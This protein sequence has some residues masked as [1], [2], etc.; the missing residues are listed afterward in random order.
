MI[1]LIMISRL[2]A[3][4]E[5][6]IHVC[7]T[8]TRLLA[9][10]GTAHKHTRLESDRRP[11]IRDHGG[12]CKI[13]CNSW[14]QR[15]VNSIARAHE[16]SGFAAACVTLLTGLTWAQASQN[17]MQSDHQNSHNVLTDHAM[18]GICP[19]T[20]MQRV[21]RTGL[22]VVSACHIRDTLSNSQKSLNTA[23]GHGPAI[24]D[25]YKASG[26]CGSQF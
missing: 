1:R 4:E 25:R 6:H 7:C 15:C 10:L 9:S 20:L 12:R 2:D 21:T 14:V 8:S 19:F 22:A 3:A 17:L 13:F 18:T 26:L 23:P 24:I 16:A 5:K 11:D